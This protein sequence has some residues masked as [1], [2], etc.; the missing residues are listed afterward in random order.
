[1]HVLSALVLVGTL[2]LI[3]AKEEGI[4]SF[5]SNA[6]GQLGQGKIS[7]S[8]ST[9]ALSSSPWGNANPVDMCSGECNKLPLRDSKG[10]LSLSVSLSLSLSLCLSVSLSLS[11]SVS[12]SLCLSLTH[13]LS[14]HIYIP[15]DC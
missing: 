6:Y 12:L 4:L 15:T 11:L 1:M 7:I 5:G 8:E 14:I 2:G 3:L 13:T 9:P 10:Y